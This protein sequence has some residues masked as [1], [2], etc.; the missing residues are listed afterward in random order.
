MTKANATGTVQTHV[1]GPAAPH[2]EVFGTTRNESRRLM[3]QWWRELTEAD[4]TE[5]PVANVFVMGSMA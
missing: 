2:A 5:R 1:G 4:E 3:D